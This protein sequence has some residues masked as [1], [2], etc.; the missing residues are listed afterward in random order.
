MQGSRLQIVQD[1]VDASPQ[2]FMVWCSPG[3]TR[4]AVQ[5]GWVLALVL[6]TVLTGCG[7]LRPHPNYEYVYVSTRRPQYLRDRVAPV[8]NHTGQVRNGE[9]LQVLDHMHRFLKVQTAQGAV[10]W[11]EEPATID[12]TVYDGFQALQIQHAKD[13]IVAHAVL[14]DDMYMHLTPG[15]KTEHFY[16]IPA[17]TKLEM[18]ERVLVPK[19]GAPA[20]A[21][22]PKSI[23]ALPRT[24]AK[25]LKHKKKAEETG[26]PV[27][28][29][30]ATPMDDWW[31]VR[32]SA[33]H[34][35]WM[36]A[37]QLDVDVPDEIAQYAEGQRMVG[38]YVLR[39]VNDPD[40]GKPNGQVPEYVTVLTPY[41]DGLPYDFD[42]VRVFTWDGKHHRYGTAFRQRNLAGYFPVTVGQKDFGSGPE[43]V[44]SINV[45]ADSNVSIDPAT[46]AVHPAQTEVLTYRLEGNL[47]RRVL[48]PGASSAAIPQRHS[49]AS[50][51]RG[52][53]RHRKPS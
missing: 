19:G 48:P 34:T 3:K 22:Q 35:G 42:Q 52:L 21:A 10:G 51:H 39:T 37:R 36:L 49:R 31:L 18:I 30:P 16:L 5:L 14:R 13:P 33:G 29:M 25:T 46:G 7:H 6:L 47:V 17:N 32:D 8:S 12:Q 38:A 50:T 9:R 27:I 2:K 41:K 1:V 40:S 44:F 43:P 26:E 24:T 28:T 45:A 11:I 4:G 53:T 20:A 23:A 15:L